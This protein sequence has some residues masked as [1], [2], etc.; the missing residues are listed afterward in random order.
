MSPRTLIFSQKNRG[1]RE[2]EKASGKTYR[3]SSLVQ[4]RAV[5]S[6]ATV[7]QRAWASLSDSPAKKTS[8]VGSMCWG[9]W[10]VKRSHP[11]LQHGH[12]CMT[13]CKDFA[14]PARSSSVPV[15]T[16]ALA[17]VIYFLACAWMCIWY[18]LLLGKAKATHGDNACHFSSSP[19]AGAPALLH[20]SSPAW[21]TSPCACV[22]TGL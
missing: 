7:H 4:S 6:R 13:K 22:H 20:T 10:S 18:V 16:C 17:L 2:D 14:V 8:K 12:A 19:S 21:G 1:T 5:H 15:F 11:K 3:M 9:V